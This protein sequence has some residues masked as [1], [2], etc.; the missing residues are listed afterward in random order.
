MEELS[1]ASYLKEG[2]FGTATHNKDGVFLYLFYKLYPLLRA[3]PP[4]V[5]GL[6]SSRLEACFFYAQ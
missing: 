4:I 6:K 1:C 5:F 2:T 3:E